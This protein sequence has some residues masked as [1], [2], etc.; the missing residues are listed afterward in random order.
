MVYL[1]IP[2]YPQV[3]FFTMNIQENALSSGQICPYSSRHSHNNF[4]VYFKRI[5]FF[6]KYLYDSKNHRCAIIKVARA[7]MGSCGVF[8]HLGVKH[9]HT[10]LGAR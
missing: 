10:A 4:M 3:V 8:G 9:Y 6:M 2:L 1:V 5:V 7:H